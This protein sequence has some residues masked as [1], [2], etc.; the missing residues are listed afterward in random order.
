M[1]VNEQIK[2][3]ET[4]HKEQTPYRSKGKGDIM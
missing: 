4:L 1:D 3:S 2:L